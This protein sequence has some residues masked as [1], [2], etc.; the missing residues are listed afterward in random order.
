MRIPGF[1]TGTPGTGAA[2][3]M[4]WRALLAPLLFATAL[5]HAL[6]GPVV[7]TVEEATPAVQEPERNTPPWADSQTPSAPDLDALLSDAT[8]VGQRSALEALSRDGIPEEQGASGGRAL[9]VGGHSLRELARSMVN[10]APAQGDG[11]A[12]PLLFTEA[13]DAA[14]PAPPDESGGAPQRSVATDAMA[15]LVTAL[16]KPTI[17]D[18][19]VVTF[20]FLGLGEFALMATGDRHSLSLSYDDSIIFSLSDAQAVAA[21][22]RIGY[23]SPWRSSGWVP[24]AQAAPRSADAPEGKLTF[25][26]LFGLLREIVTYPPLVIGVLLLLGLWALWWLVSLTRRQG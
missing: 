9:R 8:R 7:V 1:D 24:V 15:S 4:R 12:S 2:R 3:R 14:M 19:G 18:Q 17:D 20:S 10:V 25:A 6:A 21:T 22:Q 26:D 5:G 13:G 16:L 23:D 11:G